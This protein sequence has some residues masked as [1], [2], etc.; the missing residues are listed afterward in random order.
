[1]RNL[2]VITLY[3]GWNDSYKSMLK[4][5]RGIKFFSVFSG[6]SFFPDKWGIIKNEIFSFHYFLYRFRRFRDNLVLCH[7]GHLGALV[8]LKLFPFLFGKSFHL[9]IYNFYIHS[10]SNNYFVKK[11]LCFLFSNSQKYTLIVQSLFEIEYYEYLCPTLNIEFVYYCSDVKA[12]EN[13][14]VKDYIFT[15]GYTNRDY[16]LMLK[17]ARKMPTEK[18]V[19]I[20]SKLNKELI[21]EHIPSNVTVYYDVTN[22]EFEHYLA[23]SKIVVIP[24]KENVGASGQ[25][26]CLQAMR[27]RKAIIYTD[28]SSINYYFTKEAGLP[29]ELGNFSSL[30]EKM[31]YLLGNRNEIKK[32]GERAYQN[33]LHYTIDSRNQLLLEIIRKSRS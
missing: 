1:M 25:M 22:L 11:I 19:F 23:E 5:E 28:I 21:D 6:I 17:V 24:L 16:L 3:E 30:M 26:L 31:E 33:S 13:I 12:C 15:G 7:G 10:A 32:M 9:F 27:N 29:Y 20:A 4:Y 8:C 18:F 2:I 14:V